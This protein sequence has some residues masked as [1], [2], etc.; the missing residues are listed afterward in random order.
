MTITGSFHAVTAGSLEIAFL[1]HGPRDGTPV[2]LLH[3][4]PYDVHAY[5][6]VVPRLVAARCRVVVPFLRG[7]GPTRF[8]HPTTPRSGQQ[9]VLAHDLIALLD[10]LSLPDAVLGGYDWGGRA[11]CIV[12]ALWPERSRGLV[13]VGGYNL[14][15]I[16][17]AA[18]PQAPEAEY[19]YWYQYY[20]HTERGR[21]GLDRNRREFCRLLWKLWSPNWQFD[22][23]T[24]DRS[25]AAFEN[26]DFV[27]VVIHSYR[28]RFGTVAGDPDVAETERR[29][30]S[31]PSISVP[32]VVLHGDGDGVAPA[33]T[34][35]KHARHFT[36]PYQRHVIPVVGHNLPQEAPREFADAVLGLARHT[37]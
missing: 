33:S 27:D 30:E 16:P 36:G 35:E 8:L 11:A 25:A 3:G 19:R 17:G 22:D 7:F 12:S 5:D 10:A 14:Q 20:F 9:A 1:D 26:P 31:Q 34:S 15:D 18:R 4:F 37:R 24:F 29:L 6:D 28:H 13:S 32:T 21:A 23:T 2:I